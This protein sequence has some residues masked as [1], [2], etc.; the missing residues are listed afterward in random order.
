VPRAPALVI[1]PDPSG[2][3]IVG[4][5]GVFANIY[6]ILK[7]SASE[8]PGLLSNTIMGYQDFGNLNEPLS[9]FRAGRV[10]LL[11]STHE[12]LSVDRITRASDGS[13]YGLTWS[14]YLGFGYD[15]HEKRYI[16]VGKILTG[17][18]GNHN[19]F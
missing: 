7:M 18:I 16:G 9:G 4:K 10:Y 8:D 3:T 1:L 13:I 6:D 19:R 5:I 2:K 12:Y 17:T 14:I 11:G 15:A